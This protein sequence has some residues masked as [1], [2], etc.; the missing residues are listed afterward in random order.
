MAGRSRQGDA[1]TRRFHVPSAVR[2]SAARIDAAAARELV[3]NGALL[4]DVRRKD[5]PR[6]VRK[7]DP[8]ANPGRST[9]GPSLAPT[10]SRAPLRAPTSAAAGAAD[11]QVILGK[12]ALAW[13]SLARVYIKNGR[14]TG[15]SRR[16]GC[17]R[18]PCSS[19]RNRACAASLMLPKTCPQRSARPCRRFRF[20]PFPAS[21]D[22][23]SRSSRRSPSF[24][25]RCPVESVEA[26]VY[27][28]F[29]RVWP[30]PTG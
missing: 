7:L 20:S 18:T 17:S 9:R 2:G 22:S 21:F 25:R 29:S 30:S 3:A 28:E 13:E 11:L 19:G 23:R 15:R 5:D 10:G 4:V 16:S 14:K 6:G 12:A 27:R 8:P 1:P 24:S 26:A